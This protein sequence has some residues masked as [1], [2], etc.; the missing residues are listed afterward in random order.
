[1]QIPRLSNNAIFHQVSALYWLLILIFVWLWACCIS[2]QSNPSIHRDTEL[3]VLPDG[4]LNTIKRHF[5]Q[6]NFFAH[7]LGAVDLFHGTRWQFRKFCYIIWMV[8]E[9]CLFWFQQVVTRLIHLLGERLLGQYR[10]SYAARS[11]TLLGIKI[12]CCTFHVRISFSRNGDHVSCN[13]IREHRQRD[14]SRHLD[15]DPFLSC[16]VR[17][18]CCRT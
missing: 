3:A 18:R 14:L 10:R 4:L 15:C 8:S 11:E 9:V 2:K 12:K 16:F 7:T 5:P 6:V 1:M 13:S 17:C